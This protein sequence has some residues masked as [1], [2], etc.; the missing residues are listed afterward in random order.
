MAFSDA[1]NERDRAETGRNSSNHGGGDARAAAERNRDAM[2]ARNTP[3]NAPYG[4]MPRQQFRR[5]VNPTPSYEMSLRNMYELSKMMPGPMMGLRG[6][7]AAIGLGTGPEFSGATGNVHGP[8]DYDPTNRF[9][10]EGL[11][12]RMQQ[13]AGKPMM[14]RGLQYRGV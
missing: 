9:A 7:G 2:A 6:L 14:R 13:R 4:G 10:G 5:S 3:T 1:R 11:L 12:L 8:G